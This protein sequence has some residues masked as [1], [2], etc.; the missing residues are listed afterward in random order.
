MTTQTTY[1]NAITD[2][3]AYLKNHPYL[4]ELTQGRVFLRLPAKIKTSPFLRLYDSGTAP[5]ED[6]DAPW[7]QHRLGMDVWAMDNR[8][9]YL[10]NETV[11]ALYAIAH[12]QSPGVVL[13]PNGT[14][15]KNIA[16]TTSVDSPDPDTGW[17][18][19]VMDALWIVSL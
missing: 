15:V 8:D 16:I 11:L 7:L 3:Q 9:Y 1:P 14:V 17:P 12:D 19:K 6:S 10:V 18:R 5:L 2:I 13:G 4:A